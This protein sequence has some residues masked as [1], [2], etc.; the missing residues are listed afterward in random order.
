MKMPDLTTLLALA[1]KGWELPETEG[2]NPW[3]YRS[4]E[5]MRIELLTRIVEQER[6]LEN[7]HG[8]LLDLYEKWW[9]DGNSQTHLRIVT[10]LEALGAGDACCKT[11]LADLKARSQ[12]VGR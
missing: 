3:S 5:R 2:F 4:A 9:H 11:W 7:L 12:E 1:S 10:D 8:S 6:M